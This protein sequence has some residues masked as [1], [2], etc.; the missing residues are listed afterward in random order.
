MARKIGAPVY[1]LPEDISEVRAAVYTANLT[2]VSGE[3]QDG[4]DRVRQ[5]HADRHK[6]VITV[7]MEKL[8]KR[9]QKLK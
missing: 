7:L 8:F 4:D 6:G 3:A 5:S 2:F 1:A 9:R